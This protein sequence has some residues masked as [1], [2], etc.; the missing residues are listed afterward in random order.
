MTNVGTTP[1]DFTT[2]TGQF[3]LLAQD[4]NAVELSP[5]VTG[6]G[7]YDLFSDAEIAGYIAMYSGYCLYRAVAA[8]YTGLAARAAMSAKVTKDF[9]LQVDLSKRS[10]ALR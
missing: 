6:S 2:P 5:P 1:P 9:D 8:G 10:D 3:R 4:V 7:S